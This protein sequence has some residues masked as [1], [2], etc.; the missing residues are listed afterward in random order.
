M[1]AKKAKKKVLLKATKKAERI[2]RYKDAEG[3]YLDID[4]H[5]G[6]Y[7]VKIGWYLPDEGEFGLYLSNERM[8]STD[9]DETNNAIEVLKKF[10]KEHKLEM[11]LQGH[12]FEFE[13]MSMAKA[14]LRAINVALHY[15]RE[16]RP[17]PEWAQKAS[18]AGWL[19]P[20]G[21]KP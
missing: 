19:P 14:A 18:A 15:Q 2:P 17:L 13:S 3:Q 1:A 20:K 8:P 10:F 11:P 6:D 7:I 12:D 16:Q 9:G 5:V 21:W 4:E